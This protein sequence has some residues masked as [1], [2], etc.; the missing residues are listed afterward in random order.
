MKNIA[1][2]RRFQLIINFIILSFLFVW[3]FQK[4]VLNINSTF[5]LE[6]KNGIALGISLVQQDASTFNSDAQVFF[7]E[8]NRTTSYLLQS[9]SSFAQIYLDYVAV[10]DD[11]S[12]PK[13]LVI[14]SI[15]TSTNSELVPSELVMEKSPEKLIYDSNEY[16]YEFNSESFVRGK[17]YIM[18]HI[19]L[20]IV[21]IESNANIFELI[22]IDGNRPDLFPF[23]EQ[24]IGLNVAFDGSFDGKE[25]FRFSP[26]LEVVTAQKGWVGA[27]EKNDAGIER[28]HLERYSFYKIVILVF[29]LVMIPITLLL[30]NVL[31]EASGFFE[32]AF[33]LLLGLWGMHEIL[34]PVYV[35]SSALIDFIIYILYVLVIGE[36]LFE[37]LKGLY[38]HYAIKVRIKEI[39]A[40]DEF[41][42]IGNY[43]WIDVDLTGWILFDT[44]GNTF[45]FPAYV[46]RRNALV[47]IWTN[48]GADDPTNL[49]W[50]RRKS[51]WD[52]KGDTAYL[53]D[54][55]DVLIHKLPYP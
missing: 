52:D 6:G 21:P 10:Y 9:Q 55:K 41:V 45:K 40:R 27:F 23:D 16:K 11:A 33:G 34:V 17:R 38:V 26:A 30:N 4:Y 3:I 28:L 13:K 29:L 54:E 22:E 14:N 37:L 53:K 24:Q 44:A 18:P 50:N 51:V 8:N 5:H 1:R 42:V 2:L 20:G 43:G 36:I 48:P 39:N 47:N 25:I 35:P 32:V 7:Q 19:L 46:L 12:A 31:D 15:Y 49:H